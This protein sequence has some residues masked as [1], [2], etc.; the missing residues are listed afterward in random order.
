[1]FTGCLLC[2]IRTYRQTVGLRKEERE[3]ER[4]R[5]CASFPMSSLPFDETLCADAEAETLSSTSAVHVVKCN[6]IYFIMFWFADTQWH[7]F[8]I[9]Y[10]ASVQL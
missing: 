10:F 8:S 1:M 6:C 7:H 9:Y 4:G 5:K 2:G 3:R